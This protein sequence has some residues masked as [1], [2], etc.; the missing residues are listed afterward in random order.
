MEHSAVDIKCRTLHHST[1]AARSRRRILDGRRQI[2]GQPRRP[3]RDATDAAGGGSARLLVWKRGG[4]IEKRGLV[5]SPEKVWAKNLVACP[6]KI[7]G[8]S[9]RLSQWAGHKRAKMQFPNL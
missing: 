8:D 7:P 2:G 3:R 5:H 4:G 9:G 1:A 6:T